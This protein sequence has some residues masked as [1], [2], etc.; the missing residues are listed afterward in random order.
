MALDPQANLTDVYTF[1]S[2]DTRSG[3]PPGAPNMLNIIVGVR[4]LIEPGN[5]V[6]YDRFSDDVLYSIQIA[7]QR[8][9]PHGGG[10][11]FDGTTWIRYDFRFSQ[12]TANLND[13]K[14]LNTILSYGEGNGAGPIE[15]VGDG[16]QNFTQTYTVQTFPGL[17]GPAGGSRPVGPFLVP[18][19]N[20]GQRTTP[21]YNDAGGQP[22]SR[23][24]SQAALDRYT[25]ETIGTL[26]TGERVWAGMREDGFFADVAG[27]IDL[28]NPRILG[29]GGDGPDL[30]KG[31]NL[32]IYA[33]Q[34]PVD[35]LGLRS[36]DS[37]TS[38][39]S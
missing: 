36:G 13:Y 28:L 27:I 9:L 8:R 29:S 34:I 6:M 32:L 20:V 26:P 12:V 39:V 7:R 14:N 23:A 1:I 30:F 2:R 17:G 15:H 33:I 18:P 10:I 35:R 11:G 19:P 5:G 21:F 25:R 37:P 16:H 24:P 4:P 38:G 31:Y 3:A 22:I